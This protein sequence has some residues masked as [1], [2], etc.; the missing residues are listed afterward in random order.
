MVTCCRIM[1]K[2]FT[3]FTVREIHLFAYSNHCKAKKRRTVY[4]K[5]EHCTKKKTR[6]RKKNVSQKKCSRAMKWTCVRILIIERELT[7]DFVKEM[8]KFK[9]K[10]DTYA[11]RW[12][13]IKMRSFSC[14]RLCKTS[15]LNDICCCAVAFAYVW[16]NF[17]LICNFTMHV[18]I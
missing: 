2:S 1:R 4:K 9:K 15:K 6:N 12:R 7:T 14:A 17:Y 5:R 18:Y 11:N 8:I 10:T 16:F 13:E 3:K